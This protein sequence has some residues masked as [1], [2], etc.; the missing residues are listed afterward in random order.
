MC[1][2]SDANKINKIY[3]GILGDG[4]EQVGTKGEGE[5]EV[6]DVGTSTTKL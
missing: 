4:S 1:K 2:I 3:L 6:E 5:Q